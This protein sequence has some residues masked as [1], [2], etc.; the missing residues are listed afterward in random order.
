MIRSSHHVRLVLAA[1]NI[2]SRVDFNTKNV[3]FTNHI[4]ISTLLVSMIAD[5]E[6]VVNIHKSIWS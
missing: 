3:V 1:M 2:V 5:M 4:S 6:R